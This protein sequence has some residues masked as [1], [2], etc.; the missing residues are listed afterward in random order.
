MLALILTTFAK[1]HSPQRKPGSVVNRLTVYQLQEEA[2]KEKPDEEAIE[3]TGGVE[4]PKVVIRKIPLRKKHAL[5]AISKSAEISTEPIP[6]QR[7][8]VKTSP[9]VYETLAGLDPLA[10]SFSSFEVLR[11][12]LKSNK[13]VQIKDSRRA[14]RRAAAFLLMAA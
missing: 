11:T 12:S 10:E 2:L 8:S 3:H 5:P 4:Q 6:F 1:S 13:V 14:R 9:S 7:K